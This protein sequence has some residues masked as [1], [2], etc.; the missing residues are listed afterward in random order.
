MTTAGFDRTL[1]RVEAG[2]Q[3]A[4]DEIRA[5]ASSPDV[6][7][8]GML[9]DALRRR[10]HGRRATDLREAACPLDAPPDAPPPA[11]RQITVTGSAESLDAA[12]RGL[13]AIR[14]LAG[15]RPIEAFSWVDVERWAAAAPDGVPGVLRTLK[16]AG[17]DALASLPLDLMTDASGAVEQLLTS[18]FAQLRLTL[19]HAQ[20]DGH[21]DLWARA[22]ALQARF[23]GVQALSPLPRSIGALRPTTGYQDV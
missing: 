20:P 15:G 7:G 23:G 21:Q 14:A 17:L 5:L 19:E 11:A 2:E 4:P 9:A 16:T 12:V 3:L 18:G 1:G 6:L 22:S 8:L 10:L 13:D